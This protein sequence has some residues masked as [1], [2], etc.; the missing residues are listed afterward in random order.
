MF[1]HARTHEAFLPC[2][3]WGASRCEGGSQQDLKAVRT[4]AQRVMGVRADEAPEEFKRFISGKPA[5]TAFDDFAL[6]DTV[7]RDGFKGRRFKK[8]DLKNLNI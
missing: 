2:G 7:I 5:P 4:T 3:W 1:I 8:L 6:W